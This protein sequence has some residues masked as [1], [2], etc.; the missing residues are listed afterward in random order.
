MLT[1]LLIPQFRHQCLRYCLL[2]LLCSCRAG[3]ECQWPP[4][5]MAGHYRN[6][7]GTI[8]HEVTLMTNH[9][10]HLAAVAEAM[11]EVTDSTLFAAATRQFRARPRSKTRCNSTISAPLSIASGQCSAMRR[12]SAGASE[13]EI[14]A[15]VSRRRQGAK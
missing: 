15:F 7:P 3:Y 11:A 13:R 2:W 12:S 14:S 5:S 9:D 6:A 4:G 8:E 1:T 10:R